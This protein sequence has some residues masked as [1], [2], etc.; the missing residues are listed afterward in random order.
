[1]KVAHASPWPPPPVAWRVAAGLCDT[2]VPA[3]PLAWG[4]RSYP[5]TCPSPAGPTLMV[6]QTSLTSSY[7]RM[8]P[9]GLL[10]VCL[11]PGGPFLMHSNPPFFLR[12]ARSKGSHCASRVTVTLS[13]NV[14]PNT[15]C[16]PPKRPLGIAS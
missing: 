1:M 16:P 10:C 15:F 13:I 12:P 8:L 4:G 14:L 3:L 9:G 2:P 11:V 7:R 6:L 5:A